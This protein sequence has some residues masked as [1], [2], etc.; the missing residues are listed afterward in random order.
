VTNKKPCA[1]CQ[2][3]RMKLAAAVK[4]VA[5]KVSH[6]NSRKGKKQ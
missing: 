6:F 5:K 1:G 3:R 2:A 4:A